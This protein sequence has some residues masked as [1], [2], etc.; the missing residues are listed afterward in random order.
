MRK[1]E[2]SRIPQMLLKIS[3]GS[4][5]LLILL[6]PALGATSAFY[7]YNTVSYSGDLSAQRTA[8]M[9][10]YSATEVCDSAELQT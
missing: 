7:T 10:L 6:L 4:V 3:L 2:P 1:V 9:A 8:L 5:V